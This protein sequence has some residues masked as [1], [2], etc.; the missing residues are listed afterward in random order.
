VGSRT[1]ERDL[2]L[3]APSA[4][5]RRVFGICGLVDLIDPARQIDPA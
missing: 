3:R 4:F 2:S 5:T 1:E